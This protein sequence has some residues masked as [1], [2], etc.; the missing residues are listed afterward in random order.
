MTYWTWAR[1]LT[2]HLDVGRF[3]LNVHAVSL[4]VTF[5]TSVGESVILPCSYTEDKD[6]V[7]KVFW[8]HNDNIAVYEFSP[9]TN[10]PGS[11]VNIRAESFPKEYKNG[12]YSIKIKELKKADAGEYSCFIT[13]ADHYENMKLIVEPKGGEVKDEDEDKENTT[14]IFAII[15]GCIAI[16]VVFLCVV[17]ILI[18]RHKRLWIFKKP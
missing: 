11:K 13:P 5:K 1:L 16:V 15:I 3:E 6:Q 14:N 18:V 7:N 17:V 10:S 4:E 2:S 9:V 8:R 12:N